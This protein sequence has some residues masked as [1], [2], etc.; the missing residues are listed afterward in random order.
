MNPQTFHLRNQSFLF[1]CILLLVF[2]AS[3][4]APASNSWEREMGIGVPKHIPLKIKVENINNEQWA[5]DLE[6]E[7]TGE[8]N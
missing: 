3:F 2:S 1:V 4:A 5:H 8:C 6:I 7:V